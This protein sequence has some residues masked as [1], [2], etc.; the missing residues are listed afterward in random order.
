MA[1]F[2]N[3]TETTEAFCRDAPQLSIS[4]KTFETGD[5]VHLTLRS[6]HSREDSVFRLLVSGR[7]TSNHEVLASALA[8]SNGSSVFSARIIAGP[9]GE[10]TVV[11]WPLQLHCLANL[12]CAGDRSASTIDP[13]VR[14]ILYLPIDRSQKTGCNP[15]ANAPLPDRRPSCATPTVCTEPAEVQL[16]F[17]V[18]KPVPSRYTELAPKPPHCHFG[19][20]LV[21]GL[22]LN[23]TWHPHD[24]TL[25]QMRRPGSPEMVKALLSWSFR[26]FLFVGDSTMMGLC[27]QLRSKLCFG[28][29]GVKCVHAANMSHVA[30]DHAGME[31]LQYRLSWV[32]R[33]DEQAQED[34]SINLTCNCGHLGQVRER[35]LS[36]P[37]R[38]DVV[39][40]NAGQ[41][42]A[43]TGYTPAAQRAIVAAELGAWQ[44]AANLVVWATSGFPMEWRMPRENWLP[45]FCYLQAALL[46]HY[47]LNEA[48]VVRS[49]HRSVVLFD[50]HS[51]GAARDDWHNVGD[52]VHY[53]V[54]GYT[55]LAL[56][57]IQQLLETGRVRAMKHRGNTSTGS[58]SFH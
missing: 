11:A 38:F 15:W 58:R 34:R 52:A 29:G 41:H 26:R 42:L 46:H 8:S 27:L 40:L 49:Y 47:V 21:D 54:S 39:V 31:F 33:L 48:D 44:R 4:S 56:Q 7:T 12:P 9:P 50:T 36:P 6:V 1:R 3:A 2:D 45:R 22:W 53:T 35:F 10:Y 19:S 37:E 51:I 14:S 28:G 57:F 16:H 55:M 17:R 24:C 23:G 43:V 13:Q 32:V 18:A 20:S 5:A 25:Q 30:S